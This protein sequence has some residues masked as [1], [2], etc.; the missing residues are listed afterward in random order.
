[1]SGD[2]SARGTRELGGLA[3]DR[4]GFETDRQVWAIDRHYGRSI[5]RVRAIARQDGRNR[6]ALFRVETH[7]ARD[8]SA[9]GRDRSALALPGAHVWADRSA[10]MAR[11]IG[12]LSDHLC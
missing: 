7:R 6:L 9:E 12:W 4:R 2:R 10:G 11:S 5:G 3:N 1:M 8:R